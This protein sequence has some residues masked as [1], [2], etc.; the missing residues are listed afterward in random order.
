MTKTRK[1]YHRESFHLRLSDWIYEQIRIQ[2]MD[3]PSGYIFFILL[4]LGFSYGIAKIGTPYCYIVPAVLIGLAIVVECIANTRFGFYFTIFYGFLVF[5]IKRLLYPS[6]VPLGSVTE[7]L[8]LATF[9]GVIIKKIINRERGWSNSKNH[10]SI[11]YVIYLLYMGVEVLNTYGGAVEGWFF[12]YRKFLE[13]IIY[14]FIALHI[15]KDLESIKYFFKFWLAMALFAALYGCYE[16]WVGMPRFELHFILSNPVIFGLDFQGGQFRKSGPLSDPSAY[17]ILMAVT[18]IFSIILFLGPYKKRYRMLLFTGSVFTAC[19]MAASGTR[20][21]TAIFV[22]GILLFGL[23]TLNNKKSLLFFCSFLLLGSILIFGP[24]YGNNTI[25]R[26]RTTFSGNKDP[27]MEVRNIDRKQVQ[28]LIHSHPFGLG[29]ATTGVLGMSY[30]PWNPL[31]R[32]PP[33]SSY[34][35]VALELGWVGLA[36]TL[37]LYF[38][39]IKMGIDTFYQSAN[40]QIRNF[41]LAGTAVLFAWTIAQYSQEAIGQFPGSFTYYPLIAALIKLKEID[42]NRRNGVNLA[43]V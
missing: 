16:Q 3:N 30:N 36:L 20:T 28:P 8:I 25:N 38:S 4:A 33:D 31:A 41:A 7:V 2:K 26:M 9:L 18:A 15:F 14:Y 35:R 24:F 34:L 22:S 12:V 29:L 23:M 37:F 1:L 17:G 11:L 10:I 13:L 27:S 19:A 5:L 39:L 32:F 40:P 43:H 21:A 42:K 6:N